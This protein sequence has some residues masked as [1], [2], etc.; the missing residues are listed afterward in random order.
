M[1]GLPSFFIFR[2][3]TVQLVIRLRPGL[4]VGQRCAVRPVNDCHVIS[5]IREEQ[6]CSGRR[7]HIEGRRRSKLYMSEFEL[8]VSV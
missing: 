2:E 5:G 8:E 4:C 3:M 6:N 7:I 1:W